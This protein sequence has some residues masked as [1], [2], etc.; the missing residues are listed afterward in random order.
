MYIKLHKA[1]A[2]PYYGA[3]HEPAASTGFFLSSSILH[4]IPQ[5]RTT[6]PDTFCHKYTAMCFVTCTMKQ[7]G[8]YLQENAMNQHV[9]TFL[10]CPSCHTS[11]PS[12]NTPSSK[13]GQIVV[14]KWAALL[15]TKVQPTLRYQEAAAVPASRTPALLL[16]HKES[17]LCA[18]LSTIHLKRL[19][20]VISQPPGHRSRHRLE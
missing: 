16:L 18:F 10:C 15:H 19:H 6:T 7:C 14:S 12:V 2:T 4:F 1:R 3:E 9:H 8:R 5:R 20:A 11:N 13:C 17:T